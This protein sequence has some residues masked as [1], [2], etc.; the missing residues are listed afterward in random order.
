LAAPIQSYLSIN[1]WDENCDGMGYEDVVTGALLE[2]AGWHFIYDPSMLTWESHECH[3]VD[4][5][6]KRIDKGISP[7][8][9]SHA[10]L[11]STRMRKWSP[12][13]FGAEGIS[14]L[15][16]KVLQGEPFPIGQIPEHDWFD[17]QPLIEM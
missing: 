3:E 14:G 7:K 6:M 4:I 15:R 9:K 12:N 11:A 10:I 17:K 13:Y 5:P 1:G 2:N 8:D 16:Q